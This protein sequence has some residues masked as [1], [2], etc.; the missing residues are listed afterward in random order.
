MPVLER[1]RRAVQSL[2]HPSCRLLRSPPLSRSLHHQKKDWPLRGQ[3][4]GQAEPTLPETS[5]W[6][7]L[8]G[9]AKMPSWQPACCAFIFW[10]LCLSVLLIRGAFPVCFGRC[11]AFSMPSTVNG[12]ELKRHT[13]IHFLQSGQVNAFEHLHPS[14]QRDGAPPSSIAVQCT[15]FA[16]K[17]STVAGWPSQH[18]DAYEG[19]L[20]KTKN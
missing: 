10:S 14:M 16:R 13:Q 11:G 20:E 15:A 6:C 12:R 18:V 7:N 1:R 17:C 8:Q 9:P 5:F 2:Q 4:K 3:Q 19:V